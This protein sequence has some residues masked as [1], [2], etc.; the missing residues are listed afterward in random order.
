MVNVKVSFE[1]FE[2]E[3]EKINKFSIALYFIFKNI[4]MYTSEA[5]INERV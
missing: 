1:A 2:L 5:C 3:K 4:G